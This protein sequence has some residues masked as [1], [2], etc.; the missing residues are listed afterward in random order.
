MPYEY[1]KLSAKE[2]DEIVETRKQR[3]YPL[4]S[5]PHPYSGNGTYLITAANFGH[6]HVM[7]F[8]ERRSEFQELLLKSFHDINAEI[9]GWVILPNHYHILVTVESLKL[10]SNCL[11]LLHGRTSHDWNMQDGLKEKRR[12]WYRFLDHLMRD[13]KQ[14]H[15]TLN[16]VHYNP[17]KHGYVDDIFA[18]QWSSVFWYEN[19]KGGD[20]LNEQWQ[21]YEPPAEYGKD[22]D[23]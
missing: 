3:G 13:E 12:V 20:W 2:R 1:R 21:E 7:R 17:I 9:I 10:V 18:W 19:E 14:L 11:R 22:W 5:P 4:H 15:Q 16:Y 8:S 23:I 6:T